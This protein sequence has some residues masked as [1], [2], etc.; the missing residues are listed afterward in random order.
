M[1]HFSELVT[2][3]GSI[4]EHFKWGVLGQKGPSEIQTFKKT[5]WADKPKKPKKS[6]ISKVGPGPWAHGPWPI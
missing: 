1:T 4:C 5:Y 6:K 3:R 2:I